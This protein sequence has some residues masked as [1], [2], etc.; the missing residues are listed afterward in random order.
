MIDDG[1]VKEQGQ[2]RSHAPGLRHFI[3]TKNKHLLAIDSIPARGFTAAVSV[4]R[5]TPP[6]KPLSC[7]VKSNFASGS[8]YL[9]VSNL[10]GLQPSRGN[11]IPAKQKPC[12]LGGKQ[13]AKDCRSI[14][15]LPSSHPVESRDALDFS[16]RW[17]VAR[18]GSRAI[19][20]LDVLIQLCI[21]RRHTY[22]TS[23]RARNL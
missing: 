3:S 1:V 23:P 4:F 13:G 5:G 8:S 15:Y 18:C 12:L 21:E 17:N 2:E 22:H 19:D 7:V 16:R 10:M 14:C 9:S 6:A 20:Q 11:Q